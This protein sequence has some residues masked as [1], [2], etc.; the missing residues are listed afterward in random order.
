MFFLFAAF[1][2]FFYEDMVLDW[3]W[4]WIDTWVGLMMFVLKLSG[5]GIVLFIANFIIERL[6]IKKLKQEIKDQK[7][8]IVDLENKLRKS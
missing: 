8:I 2:G 7:N 6:H 3:K 5:L 4:D 1:M